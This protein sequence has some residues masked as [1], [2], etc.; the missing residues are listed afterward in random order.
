MSELTPIN[1]VA[2][3]APF[4]VRKPCPARCFNGTAP[5]P[6]KR[7]VCGL[8][9]SSLS[10]PR[11]CGLRLFGWGEGITSLKGG[12][13]GFSTKPG[14]NPRKKTVEPKGPPKA[15][16]TLKKGPGFPGVFLLGP[17]PPGKTF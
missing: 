10:R 5:P 11:I 12:E 14:E 1:C 4:P 6:G 3:P 15:P 17:P 13:Y 9:R 7:R 2:A 16:E 8:G